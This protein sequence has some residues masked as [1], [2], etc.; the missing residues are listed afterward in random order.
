MI[1][2][3][4]ACSWVTFGV[5]IWAVTPTREEQVWEERYGAPCETC[6]I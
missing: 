5:M 1:S 3:F 4:L 2:R 6:W